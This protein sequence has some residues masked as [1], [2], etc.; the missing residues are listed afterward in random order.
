MIP[1][2]QGLGHSVCMSLLAVLG[3]ASLVGSS[4]GQSICS[5]DRGL[6]Q[7]VDLSLHRKNI[8]NSLQQ[9][10]RLG[11][12]ARLRGEL[13][14]HTPNHSMG[15]WRWEG[16]AADTVVLGNPSIPHLP[17][18]FTEAPRLGMV[19]AKMPRG[20]LRPS[21]ERAGGNVGQ[22]WGC[23]NER[24]AQVSIFPDQAGRNR[25]E[26]AVAESGFVPTATG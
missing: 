23:W 21:G 16:N 22:L 14:V 7:G 3:V 13:L 19:S 8:L 1:E 6:E 18:V 15:T 5:A 17:W 26:G 24:A 4:V 25:G 11:V 2:P 12:G 9:E 20:T 10:L